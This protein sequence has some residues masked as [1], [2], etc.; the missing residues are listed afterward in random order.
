MGPRR[1]VACPVRVWG[2]FDREHV[3]IACWPEY[4]LLLVIDCVDVLGRGT[5]DQLKVISLSLTRI[6]I[7][8]EFV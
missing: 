4:F 7:L 5:V 3:L 6:V 2:I 1:K 8:N